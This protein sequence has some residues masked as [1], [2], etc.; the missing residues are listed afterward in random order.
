[1]KAHRP[2]TFLLFSILLLMTVTVFAQSSK[3]YKG[4]THTHT[5]NSDGDSTPADVV[6]WYRENRYN[7]LFLTDHEYINNVDALN[8]VYG[9]PGSFIVLSGQEV[10]DSYDKK[11]YHINALGVSKVVM[12]NKLSGAVATL[13]KNIDDVISSGGVAQVNHP[14]FGWALTAEHLIKLRNYSLL[15]IHNGHPLVNNKGGGGMPSAEEMWDSVLTGG[16]LIFG[17]ADDDAHYFKRIGDPTA[18]TPGQGWIYIRANELSEAAILGALRKGD[19]YASTG[20][21][22]SDY[23][24]TTKRIVV[25]VKELPSS[26][27]RIQFIGRGGKLLSEALSSPATYLIKG[28]ESYVRARILESNGKMAWT[29]PLMIGKSSESKL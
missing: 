29:Q 19:F 3:W 12:P 10:T 17:V 25:T 27:Y 14:N 6:K 11:P 22:L 7:F 28:D 15:E 16:K 5:L 1:M 18:P 21:E 20:V 2:P 23:Q 8:G 26:K 13:Q 4:N 24:M 9:N